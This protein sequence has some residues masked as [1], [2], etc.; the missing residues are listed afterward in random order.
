MSKFSVAMK[1]FGGFLKRN[2][3]YF[4]IVLCIASVATVIALA[5][6]RNNAQQNADIGG[7]QTLQPENP[8]GEQTPGGEQEP[9]GEEQDPGTNTP[10]PPK[11]LTFNMPCNGTMSVKYAHDEIIQSSTLGHWATHLGVDFVSDDLNVYASAD[12]EISELKSD[13]LKGN[14]IVITHENGYKT[15]YMSLADLGQFKVGD[16]ITQG[17]LLGQMSASMGE[18]L[19]E[20]AHLHFEVLKDGASINPLDVL[21]LEEK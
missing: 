12:G 2:A 15:V 1:R 16:K 10:D 6:T 3:F 5:V 11:Q 13:K 8:G 9:G 17:Q 14:Y 7:N 20:G 4:L 19:A 18:E 21:V